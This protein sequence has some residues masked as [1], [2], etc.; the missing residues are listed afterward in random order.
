MIRPH[1]SRPTC[2][3]AITRRIECEAKRSASFRF[4]NTR[5]ASW[6]L[7]FLPAVLAV[8]VAGSDYDAAWRRTDLQREDHPCSHSSKPRAPRAVQSRYTSHHLF[9]PT[10]PHHTSQC[11]THVRPTMILPSAQYFPFVLPLFVFL[12]AC[13][14]VL[15]A[16]RC[17]PRQRE[18]SCH[19]G[20]FT[21]VPGPF[22]LPACGKKKHVRKSTCE[23]SLCPHIPLAILVKR[24][25]NSAMNCFSC[26]F[27]SRASSP[28]HLSSEGEDGG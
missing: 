13:S 1:P 5:I 27:S 16:G 10:S 19:K 24:I 15:L 21:T 28:V 22:P 8:S 14:S 17:K 7:V 6:L 11:C 2:R 12:H 23:T 3:T 18:E 20:A 9:A 26:F 25:V 4:S